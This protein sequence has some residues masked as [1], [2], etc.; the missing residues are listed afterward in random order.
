MLTCHGCFDEYLH[1][2][3]KRQDPKCVDCGAPIDIAEYTLFRCD[4][5]WQLGK[6]LEVELDTEVEPDTIMGMM[7]ESK[8]KWKAVKDFVSKVQSTREEE[9]RTAQRAALREDKLSRNIIR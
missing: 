1:R 4:R 8:G 7:L 6:E 3:K 9:E 5:W 2:F